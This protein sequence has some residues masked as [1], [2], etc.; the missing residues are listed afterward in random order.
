MGFI[1]V[2]VS[3]GAVRASISMAAHEAG[4][5]VMS[6]MDS[7]ELI[8]TVEQKRPQLLFL[9]PALARM[10]TVEPLKHLAL[11]GH[12]RDM[13]VLL[14]D[15]RCAEPQAWMAVGRQLVE[16]VIDSFRKD[17]IRWAIDAAIGMGKNVASRPPAA[18]PRAPAPPS[19]P[20]PSSKAFLPPMKPL[21]TTG[22]LPAGSSPA[23][24][25]RPAPFRPARPSAAAPPPPPEAA[26]PAGP[27]VLVVEDIPSLRA[28]LGINLEA[29]GWT[30][31]WAET[32]EEAMQK[33][34]TEGCEVLL[35]DVN[36]P[37]L[38]GDQLVLLVKKRYPGVRCILMTA[39]PQERWPKVPRDIPIFPKP[40]DMEALI[41]ELSASLRKPS[42]KR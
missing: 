6:V 21:G 10:D 41:Q 29:A 25:A 24:A 5:T 11:S 20:P 38:S 8:R 19:A 4:H 26:A 22:R 7:E 30:V 12:L 28:L 34:E 18:P 17:D 39:L 13:R 23:A 2:A 42:G 36:L 16:G 40:L 37:G 15:D 32:S 1:I 9:D 33:I 27:T 35:S 31:K 14:V 3:N